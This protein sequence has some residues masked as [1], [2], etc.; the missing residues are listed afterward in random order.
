[1]IIWRF[2]AVIL[3]QSTLNLIILYLHIAFRINDSCSF[4]T[5]H[6]VYI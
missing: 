3:S 4:T 5:A 6:N 1:M 2:T